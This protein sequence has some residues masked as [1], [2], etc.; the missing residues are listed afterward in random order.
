MG[1]AALLAAAVLSFTGGDE[2]VV[3]R[4][5]GTLPSGCTPRETAELLVRFADAVTAGDAKALRRV[6]ALE[7]GDHFF[8]RP[9]PHFRWYSVTEGSWR[10]TAVYDIADLFPYFAG[11]HRAN[12]RWEVIGVDVGSSWIPGAAGIS[13]V[14]RR[15]ADDLPAS[16][17]EF[18]FGKG[19]ID[20]A[21]QRVFVWSIGQDG[22]DRLPSCPLPADWRPG[23]SIVACARTGV[24]GTGVN[25]RAALPDFRV[26]KTSARRF[27]RPC[28]PQRVSARVRS[29]L[30]AFNSGVGSAFA[31][32]FTANGLFVPANTQRVG[33]AAI[34]SLVR[35]LHASG[36]GWTASKLAAPPRVTPAQPAPRYQPRLAVYRLDLLLS[37]PGRRLET[38]GAK[39]VVYC[40]SGLIRM[41]VGPALPVPTTP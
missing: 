13:Y 22:S 16:I 20:C 10:H 35:D 40:N 28:A 39:I 4:D 41:W 37:A 32:R 34:A 8:V 9:Q 38:G 27:P 2:I 21:A 31:R 1:V 14:L 30:A 33:R 36:V 19:E 17:G 12:E 25:A 29:A 7:E 24:T 26:E 6:F 11:R 23:D 18:A 3:T 15:E 5:T